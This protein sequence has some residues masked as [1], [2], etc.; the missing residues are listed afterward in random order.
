MSDI[1]LLPPDVD[2]TPDLNLKIRIRILA[3]VILDLAEGCGVTDCEDSIKRG[4]IEQPIIEDI[5]LSFI[6]DSNVVKGEVIFH[7][8]WEKLEF[9]A[10]TNEGITVIERLD[11]NKLLAPQLDPVLCTELFNFVKRLKK[12]YNIIRTKSSYDY[13]KKYNETD[14]INNNTMKYMRHIKGEILEK[15]TKDFN[16]E[17]KAAFQGLDG[18]LD[19]IIRK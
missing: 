7:I 16:Y 17:L 11:L 2:I 9:L 3:Q 5:T 14:E 13:R 10:Q 18:Y 19:V 6:D 1:E 12:K 8:D 15:D 4:I